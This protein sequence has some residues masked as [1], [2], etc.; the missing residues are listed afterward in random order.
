[1]M[2]SSRL[3]GLRGW[4][5]DFCLW[6]L[7]C[8]FSFQRLGRLAITSTLATPLRDSAT[9]LF[10]DFEDASAESLMLSRMGCTASLTG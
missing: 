1:M 9:T 7:A 6:R 8:L 5:L 2:S 10:V 4:L 3:V